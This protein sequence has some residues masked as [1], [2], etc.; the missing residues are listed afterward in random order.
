MVNAPAISHNYIFR[1]FTSVDCAGH[2]GGDRWIREK[3]NAERRWDESGFQ[4]ADHQECTIN[5]LNNVSMPIDSS[6]GTFFFIRLAL[7]AIILSPQ[8]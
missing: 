6:E 2:H 7:E 1:I 4:Q 8:T 3:Q 5:T